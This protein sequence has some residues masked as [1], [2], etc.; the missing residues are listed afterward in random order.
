LRFL[1]N[2]QHLRVRRRID[3]EPDNVVE[4]WRQTVG[5]ATA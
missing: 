5:L 3:I 1:V 4:A 2:R